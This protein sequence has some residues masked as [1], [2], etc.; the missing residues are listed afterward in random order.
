MKN[1]IMILNICFFFLKGEGGVCC[2]KFFIWEILI[3]IDLFKF[4]FCG[5]LFICVFVLK[6]V[7]FESNL[8]IIDLF[9]FYYLFWDIN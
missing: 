6:Y 1:K 2:L 3:N 7:F 8:F 4:V 5:Y 9:L